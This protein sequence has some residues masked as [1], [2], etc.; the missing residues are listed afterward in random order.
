[1][2]GRTGLS[3]FSIMVVLAFLAASYLLPR[4]LKRRGLKPETS[5]W[6]ILLGVVGAIVGAKIGYIFEVWGK[7]WVVDQSWT[8]TFTQ[9]FFT[10]NGMANKLPG[11]AVGLWDSL[12][13]G[14]GLVFYGGLILCF[15]LITTYL[16][17]NKLP[18]WQYADACMPALAIGYGIGRMGC[19]VSGDGCFGFAAPVNIPLITMVYGPDGV[20]SS[21]GVNVWNTPMIEALAT[22]A[23]FGL[24]MWKLR[25]ITFR[26]GMLVA[27]YLFWNGLVRLLVEFIRLNDAVFALRPGPTIEMN[28]QTVPLTLEVA[29]RSQL[30]A[31][32][33]FENWYW[34]G[35]T[36]SQLVAIGLMVVA[37]AWIVIGKLWKLD[38]PE[39]P[40]EVVEEKPKKAKKKK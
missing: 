16:R 24:F 15:I 18:V 21:A 8:E 2:C 20:V 11:R 7:I 6:V 36:Q 13:D 32:A 25:Y 26:S 3:T 38:G 1:M 17:R 10:W 12:F 28:G 27:I 40:K 23:A 34:Y 4:E 30:G 14:G 31:A 9:V 5:D 19:I 29:A 37:V 33:Y 39:Q 35:P 22:W